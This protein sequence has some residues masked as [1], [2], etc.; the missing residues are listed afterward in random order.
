MASALVIT[1]MA[2]GSAQQSKRP[3]QSNNNVEDRCKL[4][5][6][7]KILSN[8]QAL[9]AASPLTLAGLKQVHIGD[10]PAE[11]FPSN[12]KAS[13]VKEPFND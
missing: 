9:S 5:V 1:S 3:H 12:H 2:G 11:I 13:Q 4:P 8:L 6:M 10:V 7:F